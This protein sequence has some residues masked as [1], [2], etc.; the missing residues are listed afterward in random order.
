M[1]ID[2]LVSSPCD[3]CDCA[4]TS[5]CCGA[6]IIMGDICSDCKEHCGDCCDECNENLN[7]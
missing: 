3:Y 1:T 2:E 7:T 5:D 4:H 6:E